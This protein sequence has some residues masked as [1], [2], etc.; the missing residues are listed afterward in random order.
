MR[1]L[2]YYQQLVERYYERWL[3]AE[4]LE[5]QDEDLL[6]DKMMEKRHEN[7]END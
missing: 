1:D 7:R 6:I 2:A 4:E 3:Y 5:P